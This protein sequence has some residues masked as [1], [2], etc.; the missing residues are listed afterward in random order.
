VIESSGLWLHFSR[1][2]EAKRKSP[3]WAGLLP[4][5]QRDALKG[6]GF[7]RAARRAKQV[8]FSL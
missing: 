8:G 5:E 1:V 4:L 6:P 2:M 7:I 3:A